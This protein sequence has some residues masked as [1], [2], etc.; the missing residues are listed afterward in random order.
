ME[1]DV[2]EGEA[3]RALRHA[4]AP[5]KGARAVASDKAEPEAA[6]GS[7]GDDAADEMD[8]GSFAHT[9]HVAAFPIGIAPERFLEEMK[10]GETQEA[11]RRLQEK[12][13]GRR[14]LLGI[15]RLD[16]IKGIPHKLLAFERLLE[17]HPEYASRSFYAPMHPHASLPSPLPYASRSFY[18]LMHPHASLPSPLPVFTAAPPRA[19]SPC[20]YVDD[21][22]LVQIAVPSRLD[23]ALHQQLQQ[24]LHLLVGR[25]NGKFGTLGEVPIHYLDTSVNFSELVALYAPPPRLPPPC[26]S[27]ST[28]C[29]IPL[30]HRRV[31]VRSGTPRLR[32]WSSRAF[33]TA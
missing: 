20:R 21:V 13:G 30:H 19:L 28:A 6:R 5:A 23:V 33:A 3:P 8:S 24:R 11:I 31:F 22:V 29:C 10:K 16:P 27:H 26:T 9:A 15:D 32:P 2:D 18:A 12:F 14:M 17:D 1:D 25:I 4:D 7:V